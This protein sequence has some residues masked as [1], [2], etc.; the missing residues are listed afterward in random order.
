[1]DTLGLLLGTS[2]FFR[3]KGMALVNFLCGGCL[4]S[5]LAKEKDTLHHPESEEGRRGHITLHS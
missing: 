4:F 3:W 1:M 2:I 5:N